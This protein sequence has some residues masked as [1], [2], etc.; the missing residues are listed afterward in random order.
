M[1]KK[2]VSYK[3][4]L[5]LKVR[6]PLPPYHKLRVANKQPGSCELLPGK[7]IHQH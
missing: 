6:P 7:G 4:A 1:S 5:A 3:D 2:R